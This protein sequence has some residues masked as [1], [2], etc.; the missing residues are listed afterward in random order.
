MN[1][2]KVKSVSKSVLYYGGLFA[3]SAAVGCG[4]VALGRATKSTPVGDAIAP[5]AEA[6][7]EVATDAAAEVVKALFNK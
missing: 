4:L 7:T 2:D 6:A 5:V 3:A 1:L